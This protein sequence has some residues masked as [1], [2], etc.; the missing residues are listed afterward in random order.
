MLRPAASAG[1]IATLLVVLDAS[2][3]GR[4]ESRAHSPRGAVAA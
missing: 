3:L 1:V 2:E 4:G